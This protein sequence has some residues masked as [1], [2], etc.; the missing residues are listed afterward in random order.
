MKFDR[1]NYYQVGIF[2]YWYLHNL[3]PHSFIEYFTKV[4]DV[5]KH[6]TW[7][8]GGLSIQYARPNQYRSSIACTG[9]KIYGIPASI[10]EAP[11]FFSNLNDFGASSV[12]YFLQDEFKRMVKPLGYG[13][14]FN[15]MFC[16]LIKFF[17]VDST[18]MTTSVLLKQ[19]A[20]NSWANVPF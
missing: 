7:F 15:F 8:S 14:D 4:E 10:K 18:C 5:H 3:I 9:P 20:L 6:Y 12:S 11:A 2:M 13:N 16:V 19:A 17:L 1:V